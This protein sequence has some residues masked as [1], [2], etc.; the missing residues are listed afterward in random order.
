VKIDASVARQLIASQ[1]PEWANLPTAPVE[2]P[3]CDVTI[4]RTLLSGESRNAFR[5]ALPVDD[6]TWVRSSGWALWKG[7]ITLARH[8]D[9]YPAEAA[10]ARHVVEEVLAEC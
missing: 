4:A 3:A 6:A 10:I 2:D 1:F 9:T 5:G 8:I 7:L